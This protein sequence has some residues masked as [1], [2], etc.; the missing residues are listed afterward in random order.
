MARNAGIQ[1]SSSRFAC[2]KIDDDEENLKKT[3]TK[4]NQQQQQ[5]NAQ[6]K[7]NQKKKNQKDTND[8]RAL[9]FGGSGGGKGSAKKRQMGAGDQSTNSDWDHWKQHD[10]EFTEDKF[11]DDLEKALLE[12]RLENEKAK[13]EKKEQ[14][15][16][17]EAGIELPTTKEEKKKQKQKSKPQKMSLEQ[18]NQLPPEKVPN[19][20]DDE[21]GNMN[22][23]D[24]GPS[25]H[26]RVPTTQQ[27][28]KFFN[29]VKDD[30][31]EILRGERM[32]EEYRKHFATDNAVV[33]KLKNDLEKKD[34]KVKELEE[35]MNTMAAELK[36]VKKRNKQLCVILA[37]GEMKDKATV[38]LQVDELTSVRDELSEQ[39]TTLTAD[40]EKEK[41][42]NR[43]LKVEMDKLK[44]KP[45]K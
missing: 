27:D 24:S 8:L 28:A 9:A 35:K 14:K 36:Q 38:L 16:R 25:I 4:N 26:T 33:S 37:Q 5:A 22:D 10:Q 2:L 41:S 44:A 12:S 18:F 23:I 6:K 19:S 34:M 40:L 1:I 42:K 39:V 30:A 21:D 20:S 17:I 32:Q 31:E 13:H 3:Q 15:A 45:A 43:S 7:K 29:S 11:K